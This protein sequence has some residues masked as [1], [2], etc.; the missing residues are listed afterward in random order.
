MNMSKKIIGGI[1]AIAL[2]L[3]FFSNGYAQNATE[4]GPVTPRIL[5]L[6]GNSTVTARPTDAQKAAAGLQG[7]EPNNTNI[8][9]GAVG[10]A[11]V[12]PPPQGYQNKVENI[13]HVP[14]SLEANTTKTVT[15]SGKVSSVFVANPGLVTVRPISSHRLILFGLKAGRTSVTAV[16]QSGNPITSFSVLVT[17][18]NYDAQQID[19]ILPKGASASP[20]PGAMR[21]KGTVETPLEA[22]QA[23]QAAQAAAGKGTTVIND[24]NV[25]QSQQVILLVRVAEMSRS[26]TQQLG[27]DWQTATPATL[28]AVGAKTALSGGLE[29]AVGGTPIPALPLKPGGFL[30]GDSAG[31]L[32]GNG[33]PGNYTLHFPHSNLDGVLNALDEDNLAHLLAE[34]TLT[35]LSGHTASFISGGS[36]P[37]PVPGANGQTSVNFQNYGVQLQFTPIV[38]SNG[39]IYMHVAP[40]VS[41]VSN[42]NSV[43]VSAGNSSLVVPSLI[44]QSANTTVMLG[45]GQTLAIAGLL[46][47]Q[48]TQSNA[49]VPGLG[50]VPVL[51]AAFRNDNWTR[52]QDELVILVTPYIVK[53]QDNPNAFHLPGHNWTPP[54][55]VQR[56]LLDRQS[57]GPRKMRVLPNNVGFILK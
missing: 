48:S 37:V 57:G 52:S 41:Q 7:V 8:P 43:S 11:A 5:K 12:P 45:S 29:V 20:M 53:P 44:Q 49:S 17:P 51:G 10:S 14:V 50:D 46:E 13:G 2:S 4:Q 31:T 36:F 35:A 47:N 26:V 24:I 40:T 21:L 23:Y 54:N 55:L 34:P 39:E 3:V 42:L 16:D 27:I 1:S 33:A 6:Q 38:L 25:R 56:Y 32:I 18:S 28:A 15:I 22:K 19:R 30:Q 9:V